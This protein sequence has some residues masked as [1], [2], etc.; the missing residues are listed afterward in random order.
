M[1]GYNPSECLMI[2]DSFKHDIAPALELGMEVIWITKEK[3]EFYQTI[4]SVYE[5]KNI[6]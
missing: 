5:L 4:E 1:D 2:G 3:S 6:L